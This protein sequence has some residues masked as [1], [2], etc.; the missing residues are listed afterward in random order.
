M[1]AAELSQPFSM[2]YVFIA[3][4]IAAAGLGVMAS[5]FRS[6]GGSSIRVRMPLMNTTIG[7][8]CISFWCFAMAAV[9]F[10]R[11]FHWVVVTSHEGWFY[12]G[13]FGSLL[14]G[15]AY[16]YLTLKRERFGR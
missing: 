11:A 10:A 2:I 13:G 4:V 7:R 6:R 15:I 12:A 9:G 8:V 3:S 1:I 16:G 14:F 5:A